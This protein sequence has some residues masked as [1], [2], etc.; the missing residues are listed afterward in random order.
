MR[1]VLADGEAHCL[2]HDLVGVSI[3]HGERIDVA[4]ADDDITWLETRIR[5][6]GALG[7]RTGCV[8]V[9]IVESLGCGRSGQTGSLSAR[10]AFHDLSPDFVREF[11]V[12]NMIRGLPFP[13]DF[14]D[15]STSIKQSSVMR[16]RE[17]CD[18]SMSF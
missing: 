13:D 5:V 16:L 4:V 14:S 7:D 11:E 8:H 6:A 12:V 17:I 15:G 3:H 18:A 10:I 9:Q 1:I 2:P